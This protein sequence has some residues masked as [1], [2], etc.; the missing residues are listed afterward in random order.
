MKVEVGNAT[1]IEGYRESEEGPV[2]YRNLE[3]ERVTT[4]ILPDDLN[5]FEAVQTVAATMTAHMQ[6][7]TVPVWIEADDPVLQAYLCNHY[8]I[9][10]TS[11]RPASWGKNADPTPQKTPAAKKKAAAKK[12]APEAP[13]A[14][15]DT[16]ES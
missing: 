6:P 7:E 5:V 15:D 10:T 2:L 14:E 11:A 4:L 16:Q 8:K 1:A 9:P 13:A 12:P 3:G